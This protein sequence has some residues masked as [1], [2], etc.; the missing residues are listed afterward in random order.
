MEN[1]EYFD[2]YELS[3]LKELLNICKSSGVMGKDI[4]SNEDIDSKWHEFEPEYMV[5]AV[6]L[7]NSYPEF[8]LGCAGYV[9]MAVA[10]WWD[11]NWDAYRSS[12]F[13][14][15]FG[16]RGFDDMDDHIISRILSYELDSEE[17]QKLSSIM[18]SC[19]QHTMDKIRHEEIE[20]ATTKA[21]YIL[22]RSLRAIFR[23]G[24]SIELFKEGYKFKLHYIS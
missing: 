8:T 14:D 6:K 12:K 21:F 24:A 18:L 17:A 3:L 4:L 13:E 16:E 7:I 15:L 5:K 10:K 23:I 9:G 19:A 11:E 1:Q 20:D 22:S 2:K